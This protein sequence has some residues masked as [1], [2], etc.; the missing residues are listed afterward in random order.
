MEENPKRGKKE[1]VEN[2]RRLKRDCCRL[3]ISEYDRCR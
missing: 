3:G 1:L 2:W